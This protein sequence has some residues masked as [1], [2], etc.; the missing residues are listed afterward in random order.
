MADENTDRTCDESEFRACLAVVG[1]GGLPGSKASSGRP[2]QRKRLTPEEKEC[3]DICGAL[4]AAM[5]LRIQSSVET[6]GPAMLEA[7]DARLFVMIKDACDLLF[8]TAFHFVPEVP[9]IS[10]PDVVNWRALLA[11]GDSTE[12]PVVW[13]NVC[14]ASAIDNLLVYNHHDPRESHN[15]ADKACACL[16]PDLFNPVH[17]LPRIDNVAH[18]ATD[19]VMWFDIAISTHI[20]WFAFKRTLRWVAVKVL[21]SNKDASIP[22]RSDAEL[23]YVTKAP[24]TCVLRCQLR[25]ASADDEKPSV[26]EKAQRC[27]LRG[28]RAVDAQNAYWSIKVCVLYPPPTADAPQ[29]E[30]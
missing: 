23:D 7:I 25:K 4:R 13:W 20:P 9:Q 21:G 14:Y 5:F 12:A 18:P 2:V 11:S 29:P 3:S 30:P 26:D 22:Q 15:H 24:C 19:G 6:I 8:V 16:A 10:D 17:E 1:R 28:W 27:T